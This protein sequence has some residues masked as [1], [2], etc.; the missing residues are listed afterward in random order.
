MKP[1]GT[2][3]V[4]SAWPSRRNGDRSDPT[5]RRPD[6]ETSASGDGQVLRMHNAKN[7]L[8]ASVRSV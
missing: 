1:K 5:R 8:N 6:A 2:V 7:I 3:S 4:N